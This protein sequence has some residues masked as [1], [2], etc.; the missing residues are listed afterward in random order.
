MAVVTSVLPIGHPSNG[1]EQPER[2][3]ADV[4]YTSIGCQRASTA[5]L[6]LCDEHYESIR[7]NPERNHP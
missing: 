3:W 4:P 5:P 7:P 6:D 1:R 2:C